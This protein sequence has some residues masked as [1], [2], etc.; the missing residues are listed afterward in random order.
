MR[1][2]T[3]RHGTTV[4][5]PELPKRLI[6]TGGARGIGYAFSEHLA[7]LG[8]RVVIAD[9]RG[10]EE[11]AARLR[12]AGRQAIGVR[13][14]VLSQAGVPGPAAARVPPVRGLDSLAHTPPPLPPPTLHP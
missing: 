8:H 9:L 10:A 5:K 12:Q 6:V 7:Q 4:M 2:R 13:A 3:I 11:A 1:Y 14:A